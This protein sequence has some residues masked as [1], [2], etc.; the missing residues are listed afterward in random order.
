M[1]VFILNP[2]P[3]YKEPMIIIPCIPK[4]TLRNNMKNTAIRLSVVTE[5]QAII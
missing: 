3:P 2:P 1:K 5:G 4:E